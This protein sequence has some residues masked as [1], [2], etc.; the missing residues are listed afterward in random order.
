MKNISKI[1][2]DK[3]RKYKLVIDI[4]TANFIEDALAYDIGYAVSDK[5]GNIYLK[6]SL[7][8]AELF[9]D[10]KDLLQSAYYSNK[11]PKYWEDYKNKKRRLVTFYTAKKEN[12]V[13]TIIK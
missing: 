7:M 4:E 10:H 1:K 12:Q 6:G 13:K 3:R 8:I 2:I 5:H 9:I 11:I